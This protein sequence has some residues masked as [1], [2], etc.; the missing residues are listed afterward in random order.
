MRRC[1]AVHVTG[2]SFSAYRQ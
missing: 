1:A 2:S